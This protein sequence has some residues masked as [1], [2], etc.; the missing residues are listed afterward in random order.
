MKRTASTFT[1]TLTLG[2]VFAIQTTAWPQ[3]SGDQNSGPQ[4]PSASRLQPTLFRQGMTRLSIIG[5]S[6]AAFDQRYFI[7]GAGGGYYV[8]DG[9]ELGLDFEAWLGNDPML[10]KLSPQLRYVAYMVPVVH[11][12]GGLFYRHLFVEDFEDLESIGLRGGLFYVIGGRA[13]LAMGVV[14]EFF[15]GCDER[16]YRSCSDT[17]PEFLLSLVF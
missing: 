10:V 9:L 4:P 15:L 5:G 3:P 8:L 6:G 2:S 17:Y 16:R 1:F 12:Y 14:Q 11:P 7:L 13:A